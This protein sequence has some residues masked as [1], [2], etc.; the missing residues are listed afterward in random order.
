[1]LLIRAKFSI[2]SSMTWF[3]LKLFEASILTFCSKSSIFMPPCELYHL[4]RTE[5]VLTN[6]K[7]VLSHLYPFTRYIIFNLVEDFWNGISVL[8]VLCKFGHF[9]IFGFLFCEITLQSMISFRVSEGDTKPYIESLWII[10]WWSLM[11]M[12]M[13]LH[14]LSFRVS[15]GDTKS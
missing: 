3:S 11:K 10:S 13:T 4:I 14:K 15:E 5:I 12:R 8:W 2:N 1:M 7:T 9:R 6:L